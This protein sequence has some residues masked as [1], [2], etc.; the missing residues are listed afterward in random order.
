MLPAILSNLAVSFF[1]S[2]SS[3]HNAEEWAS[4]RR[5]AGWTFHYSLRTC[6]SHQQAESA[7]TWA[8]LNAVYLIKSVILSGVV[9]SGAR[10]DA[11]EK[12]VLS[13]AEGTPCP[14]A[15]QRPKREFCRWPR[16]RAFCD[17]RGQW[18]PAP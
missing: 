1:A 11:V 10:D 4:H 7:L 12:P 2:N 17:L 13:E 3:A 5:R 16:T 15:A 6:H 8:P 18:L 14:P 9:A